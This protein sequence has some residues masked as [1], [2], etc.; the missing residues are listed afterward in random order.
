MT[1]CPSSWL[2]HRGGTG[3]R[4][5]AGGGAVR[6]Q[7]RQ[8][9]GGRGH[10]VRGAGRCHGVVRGDA[11]PAAAH[12]R[13]LRQHLDRDRGQPDPRR[14]GHE[15]P[16]RHRR[17]AAAEQRRTRRARS[18]ALDATITWTA[19]GIK[20][21]VQDSIPLV[22]GF[23]NDVTTNPSDGTIELEAAL[24]SSITTKPAVQDG[25]LA[26]QVVNLS[27]LGFT[28]AARDGA[29]RAGRVLHAA[30]QQLSARHSSRRRSGHRYRCDGTFFDQERVDPGGQRRPLLRRALS[31]AR[32]APR[33]CP[34]APAGWRP[35]PTSRRRRRRCGCHRWP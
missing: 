25:A 12:D 16:G 8:R 10:R 17:R 34:T 29:A 27:G 20:Q 19:E 5:R 7:P 28:L 11:V 30:D 23:V 6:A 31:Q 35:R 4:G 2:R 13:A 26:L 18:A 3:R 22:G 9:R 21:T 14:Q 33:G 15:G 24:G 32:R 1:R